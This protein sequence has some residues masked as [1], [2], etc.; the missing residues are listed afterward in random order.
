MEHSLTEGRGVDQSQ[1]QYAPGQQYAPAQPQQQLPYYQPVRYVPAPPPQPAPPPTPVTAYKNSLR[2]T[3][4]RISIALF[5]FYMANIAVVI[6]IMVGYMMLSGAV[7]SMFD[8]A[9]EG[10]VA[11]TQPARTITLSD[12]PYGLASI[13]GII[14]GTLALFIVRGRHLVT[15]DLTRTS[16]RMRASEFLKMVGLMLGCQAIISLLPLLFML[17]LYSL[18]ISPG[19][20]TETMLDP[21]MNVPGFLYVVILGPIFEEIIFRGAIMRALQPY[22]RNFALVLSSL[23]FGAYHLVLFQGIFAFFVGLILGYCA[24]RFSIKWSMLLHMLNNAL[25][26][27]VTIAEPALLIESGMYLLYLAAA[28]IAGVLSLKQFRAQLR[29]GKPES[30]PFALGAPLPDGYSLASLTKPKPFALAFSSAWLIVLLSLAFI[31][32]IVIGFIL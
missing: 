4:M 20:S 6:L 31:I 5:M 28:I 14:T 26:M 8:T 23:L 3:V 18:G 10:A 27:A 9:R 29:T 19:N 24:M 12:F 17:L 13:V 7:G 1:S 15:T 32:T 11:Y 16:E 2:E 25:A 30:M 21:Y 22:G